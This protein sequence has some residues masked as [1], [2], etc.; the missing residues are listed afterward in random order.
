M[1]LGSL[2][3]RSGLGVLIARAGWR[4]SHSVWRLVRRLR[5]NG[6]E[7]IVQKSLES[8]KERVPEGK[9]KLR[10]LLSGLCHC[11]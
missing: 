3:E 11:I 10:S 4:G 5:R 6:D 1:T 2:R 9:G 8:L 7:A